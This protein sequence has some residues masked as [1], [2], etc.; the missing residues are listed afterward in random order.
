MESVWVAMDMR[1]TV[2]VCEAMVMV[3]RTWTRCGKTPTDVHHR[4]T[5]ARGGLILD[6]FGEKYHLM[7]L[8]RSHHSIAHDHPALET[9]LLLDGWIITCS[10]CKRPTY[11]GSD[12]YLTGRY[13]WQVHLS[14]V[15]NDVR[16]S[17]AGEDLRGEAS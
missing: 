11:E 13:G 1:W 14:C 3:G 10:T 17:E 12:V 4:I 9:G 16:G 8:C 7:D 5:R 2:K 6:E 15:R